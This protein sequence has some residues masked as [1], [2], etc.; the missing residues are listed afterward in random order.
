MK[1]YSETLAND[2]NSV[3]LRADGKFNQTKM[4]WPH[5][6]LCSKILA[7]T[8]FLPKDSSLTTRV[9]Y[10]LNDMNTIRK[11]SVC[12]T[13]LFSDIKSLYYSPT[14]TCSMKACRDEARR[15][16]LFSKYGEDYF[17][18]WSSKLSKTNV[19]RY[20]VSNAMD[21]SMIRVK[22]QVNAKAKVDACREQIL[23]KRIDT[24][25]SKYG[26]VN[27]GQLPDHDAKMK[28]TSMEKYGAIS[29]S[30]TDSCKVKVRKAYEKWT[31]EMWSDRAIR[32]CN[33][34]KRRY[35][36]AS[37]QAIPYV[38]KNR[39]SRY[40]YNDMYFDSSY[41]LIYYIWA[42]DNG[43]N[44]ERC[45]KSFEYEV[46]GTTHLYIPDFIDDGRLV[47][48]KGEHFFNSSGELINPFTSDDSIQKVFKAKGKLMESMNVMVVKN[49]D[50]MK[51]FVYS[52]YGSSYISTFRI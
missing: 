39:R 19:E 38:I 26:V 35:G 51:A 21:N 34:L 27:V 32:S 49:V 7:E 47:E 20:G 30:C 13:E 45:T 9:W 46:D 16:T 41:E 42:L 52:K 12:G 4:L 17:S 29:Y 36:V 23:Q 8:S 3:L 33:T 15:R 48:I 5:K 11:C 2:I 6:E 28:R 37:V 50:V 40:C 10:I 25:S 24:V 31:P 1:N 18:Q 44:I 14:L 43:H 22:Q